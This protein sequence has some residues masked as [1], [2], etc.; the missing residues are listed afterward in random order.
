MPNQFQGVGNLGDAPSVKN[1]VN[2]GR[3]FKAGE[4]R[5]FF[6]EYSKNEKGDFEQSGG[7]WLGVTT[8]DRIAENCARLLQKG[9]RVKVEGRLT[10]F[11]AHDRD[12]NAVTAFSVVATA[13][14]LAPARV[15]SVQF[16]EPRGRSHSREVSDLPAN[17]SDYEEFHEMEPPT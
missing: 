8:Y 1:C 5:V 11:E 6:D 9:A 15:E 16:S 13:V 14:Y 2:N 10:Q 4:M 7:M 17:G 12:G 3:K